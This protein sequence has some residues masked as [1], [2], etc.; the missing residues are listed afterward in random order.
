MYEPKSPIS[1]FWFNEPSVLLNKNHITEIWPS[2]EMD[3]TQKINAVSRLIIILT[4]LGYLFTKNTHIILSGIASLLLLFLIWRLNTLRVV[5]NVEDH[6][7]EGFSPSR[8]SEPVFKPE[9]SIKEQTVNGK[10]IEDF[11]QKEFQSGTPS[12]PFANVLL[13]DIMDHPDRKPARPAYDPK[14]K[15][16][17]QKN[18]ITSIKLANTELK[19]IDEKMFG[20]VNDKYVLDTSLRQFFSNPSTVI[21]GDQGAFAQFLYGGEPS[22]KEQNAKGSLRRYENAYRHTLR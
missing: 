18:V 21:G 4:P 5:D 2:K 16:D 10:P 19:N 9:Q 22:S 17:I 15:A 12:N 11:M 8:H 3:F 14:V 1:L 6:T 20:N 7:T 13:T